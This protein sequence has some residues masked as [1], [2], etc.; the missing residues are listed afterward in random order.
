MRV[1]DRVIEDQ[2]EALDDDETSA[3]AADL[4]EVVKC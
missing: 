1:R 2:M 4:T 3:T